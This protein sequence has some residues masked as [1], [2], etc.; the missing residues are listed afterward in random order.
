MALAVEEAPPLSLCGIPRGCLCVMA[1]NADF[2]T[3]NRGGFIPQARHGGSGVRAL[4]VAGSKLE[5]TGL[6][7]EHMGQTHVALTVGGGAGDEAS[8]RWGLP[9]LSGV[10]GTVA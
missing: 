4:A 2:T 7:K 1:A 6:E 9:C 8:D 5:G 10:V 3:S